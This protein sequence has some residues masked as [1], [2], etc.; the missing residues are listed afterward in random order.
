MRAGPLVSAL[1]NKLGCRP[2]VIVGSLMASMAFGLSAS[3]SEVGLFI[4]LYGI[5]GGMASA[6]FPDR[7]LG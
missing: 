6:T 2:V 7:L 3:A 5:V 1:V 4:F